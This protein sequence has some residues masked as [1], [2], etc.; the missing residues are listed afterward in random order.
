MK[1]VSVYIF[2]GLLV[3]SYIVM[4]LHNKTLHTNQTI[5]SLIQKKYNPSNKLHKVNKENQMR[6][7]IE[8][9]TTKRMVDIP[10][11]NPYGGMGQPVTGQPPSQFQNFDPH[12]REPEETKVFQQGSTK[13]FSCESQSYQQPNRNDSRDYSF[14]NPSKCFDCEKQVKQCN[15]GN[16]GNGGNGYM[17]F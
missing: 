11:S 4:G 8:T 2:L 10:R 16:G 13:C 1:Y 14:N 12:N 17:G 6:C 7:S 9:P 3:L 15:G 5:S